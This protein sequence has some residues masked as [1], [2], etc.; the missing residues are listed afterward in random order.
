MLGCCIVFLFALLDAQLKANEYNQRLAAGILPESEW[1]GG[2][3]DP[4]G[5]QSFFELRSMLVILAG[6][7]FI[8][9]Y[10]IYHLIKL[11][12]KVGKRQT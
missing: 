2:E 12:A 9:G 11:S 6:V 7:L 5:W 8:F 10:F 4:Q 3:T 1:L